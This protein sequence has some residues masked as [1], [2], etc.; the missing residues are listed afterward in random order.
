MPTDIGTGVGSTRPRVPRRAITGHGQVKS[1]ASEDP[2]AYRYHYSPEENFEGIQKS[3][4][5]DPG[6]AKGHSKGVHFSDNPNTYRPTGGQ[7]YNVYRTPAD[8]HDFQNVSSDDFYTKEQVRHPE[9]YTETP[10]GMPHWSGLSN[11]YS[12]GSNVKGLYDLAAMLMPGILPQIRT[13]ADWVMQDVLERGDSSPWNP[14][15]QM[16]Y[17][18]QA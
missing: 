15:N 11:A 8:A 3:G 1:L 6:K 4:M 16:G 10:E 18:T 2:S 14:K 9:V 7:G 5:L 13:P 17:V 12:I